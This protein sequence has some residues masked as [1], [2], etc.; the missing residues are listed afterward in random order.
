MKEKDFIENL[1]KNNGICV[2]KDNIKKEKKEK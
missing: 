2:D 1:E